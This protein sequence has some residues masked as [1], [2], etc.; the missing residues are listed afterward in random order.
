M[1]TQAL[2]SGGRMASRFARLALALAVAALI[3]GCA[4]KPQETAASAEPASEPAYAENEAP[5]PDSIDGGEESDDLLY[6]EFED[7]YAEED[8]DVNDPL[9]ELNRAIFE[10]NRG[11]DALLLKPMAIIY[12]GIM[13]PWGRHRVTNILNNLGEPLNLANSLLQGEIERA[14]SSFMRFAVN[15]TVGVAGAFDVAGD[16]GMRR[17]NEDFGQTLAVWGVP[18]G[19]FLM[20]PIFGPSNPRDATGLVIDYLMDPFT[21]ILD[22]DVSLA[23]SVTRGVSRRAENLENLDTLEETSLDFYAALRELYRQYR[24]NAIENGGSE[25]EANGSAVDIPDYSDEV[26]LSSESE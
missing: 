3:A 10:F 16:L 7:L 20:L 1:E 11:V 18:E 6:E 8:Y 25:P 15:S 17:A 14:T 5:R 21:Y 23:R 24:N 13:P 2:K 26:A 19:P 9:E 4:S 22:D 12:N